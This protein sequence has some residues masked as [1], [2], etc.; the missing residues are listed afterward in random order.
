MFAGLGSRLLTAMSS[1][2]AL[3]NFVGML[4]TDDGV[5]GANRGRPLPVLWNKSRTS[6][7]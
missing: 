6:V 2:P 1:Y 3:E 4:E 7:S 5:V